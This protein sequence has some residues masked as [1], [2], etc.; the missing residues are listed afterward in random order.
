MWKWKWR[1]YR[2]ADL[3][4]LVVARV[5][6]PNVHTGVVWL[7]SSFERQGW[8]RT[9]D[10]SSFCFCFPVSHRF[11]EKGVVSSNGLFVLGNFGTVMLVF[12]AFPSST[13]YVAA[14]EPWKRRVATARPAT[15]AVLR[16]L[17]YHQNIFW[18]RN[19]LRSWMHRDCFLASYVGAK[20]SES[21]IWLRWKP[22][23]LI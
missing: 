19:T 12:Y 7:T 22:D 8:P 16:K 17:E 10:T 9:S 18:D 2:A 5:A 6:S 21:S 4:K 23:E 1:P 13:P 15:S 14:V 20:I 3:L 11:V